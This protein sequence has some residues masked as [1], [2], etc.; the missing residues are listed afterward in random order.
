MDSLKFVERARG[1][2]ARPGFTPDLPWFDFFDESRLDG[3]AGYASLR[4]GRFDEAEGFLARTISRLPDQAVKQHAV[5]LA[6]LATVHLSKGELDHACSIAAQAADRLRVAGYATGS[7]RLHTFRSRVAPWSSSA[8][9]RAL[10]QHLA[11]T[12]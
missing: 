2:L 8:A 10:D 9:V 5:V 7:D 11:L 6:D 1:A 4:A 12:A 3:F